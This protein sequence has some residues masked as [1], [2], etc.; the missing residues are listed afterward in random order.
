M[1]QVRLEQENISIKCIEGNRV[2]FAN[3]L[4]AVYDFN[5]TLGLH[6]YKRK[7]TIV[8]RLPYAGSVAQPR[9]WRTLLTGTEQIHWK[10][11]RWIILD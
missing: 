4:N 8:L 7:M 1:I 5:A 2:S 9:Q 6:R 3:S 10:L 11:S